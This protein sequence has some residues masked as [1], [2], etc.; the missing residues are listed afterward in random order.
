MLDINDYFN[1]DIVRWKNEIVR[2]SIQI[3]SHASGRP[4]LLSDRLVNPLDDK[5]MDPLSMAW[6]T[7]KMRE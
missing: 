7:R 6:F 1:N 5:L 4:I 3:D 2:R